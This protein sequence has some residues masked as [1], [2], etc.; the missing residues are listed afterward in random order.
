MHKRILEEKD[1]KTFAY[2]INTV[3]FKKN[4][5]KPEDLSKVPDGFYQWIMNR[6]DFQ[7]IPQT[8]TKILS[9][10]GKPA[11]Y[12]CFWKQ[13][14]ENENIPFLVQR[15][16]SAVYAYQV[17]KGNS[18]PIPVITVVLYFGKK[19]WKSSLGTK[20]ILEKS[21]DIPEEILCNSPNYKLNLVD[22]ASLPE[23]I[24]EECYCLDFS[25]DYERK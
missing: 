2:V 23:D 13:T 14:T 3:Y 21:G 25:C 5:V 9:K 22:V 8:V 20:D 17:E 19:K 1:K 15:Y 18:I 11:A 12:L 4:F 7:P 24:R 6:L 16:E 10:D